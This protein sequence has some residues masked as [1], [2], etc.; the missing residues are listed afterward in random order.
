MTSL[1]ANQLIETNRQSWRN[2]GDLNLS[3]GSS[4]L[5]SVTDSDHDWRRWCTPPPARAEGSP[6]P[7]GTWPRL[8]SHRV[9]RQLS[10]SA[11]KSSRGGAG[12]LHDGGHGSDR[13]SSLGVTAP[14]RAVTFH[15][16]H[17][18][19]CA[20]SLGASSEVR[21]ETVYLGPERRRKLAGG[22][23]VR[24]WVS[25][26]A[27]PSVRHGTARR[28]SDQLRQCRC[29]ITRIADLRIPIR[30]YLLLIG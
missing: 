17:K 25:H 5:Y 18:P 14:G 6:C 30:S 24:P 20:P 3:E 9:T 27:V 7:T 21:P 4:I 8:S 12:R 29:L 23:R 19:I 10:R 2:R 15:S 11:V 1:K 26:T 28:H 13:A 16:W 22:H